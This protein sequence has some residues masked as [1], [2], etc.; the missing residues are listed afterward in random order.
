MSQCTVAQLYYDK[1]PIKEKS[2]RVM[3]LKL[4]R[5]DDWGSWEI[6][7]DQSPTYAYGDVSRKC[8]NMCN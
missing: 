3:W 1:K 7:Y 8:I 4:V 5:K 6:G 2:S